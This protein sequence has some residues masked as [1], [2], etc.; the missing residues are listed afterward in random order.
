[1]LSALLVAT[2]AR[3]D[4]PRFVSQ[5]PHLE[6]TAR[7]AW[8]AAEVCTGWSAPAHEQVS[9]ASRYVRGGYAGGARLD[10]EGLA[11]VILWSDM[12]ERALVHE[13][14]HAWARSGP[15]TLTEGRA[16]LLADCMAE[17]VPGLAP[18]DP[19]PGRDLQLMPDLR[20]WDSGEEGPVTDLVALRSD[21]YLASA[22]FVR[23]LGSV[24]PP[25]ALWPRAGRLDW[26]D[27]ED[28][29]VEAG[30]R[31]QIVLSV[32][33]S[34]VARQ[35]E[36]LSD[37]DRDGQPWLAEVL[38][39]THPERWDSDG[40]GWWD[41]AAPRVAAVPLPL[42]GTRICSG[43]AGGVEPGRA[44]VLARGDLRGAGASVALYAGDRP[45]FGDPLSGIAVPPEAPLL[46]ALEGRI[47]A[48]TGG[49]WALTGGQ[50][51]VLDWNCRSTPRYTIWVEDPL[52]ALQLDRFD[53]E[54]SEQLDRAR[55]VLGGPAPR[56]LVLVLGASDAAITED[57]V[58]VSTGW[59][60]WARQTG[61]VDALAGVAVAL[62]RVWR[63]DP[64]ERRWDTAEALLRE[65][66]D[67]A[68]DL[69][70]VAVDLGLVGQRRAAV[71]RCREGWS[72]LLAGRCDEGVRLGP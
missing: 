39:G 6:Q 41:G 5:D 19:D 36:A 50:G 15:P 23:L 35:R 58:R 61:R 69:T 48:V 1:M 17:A 3:A 33:E 22:R 37:R 24:L 47:D 54:I 52:A 31:G 21:A 40:D 72:G 30:P 56:R 57:E 16:D 60:D 18:L 68:P 46:L 65:L 55:V 10:A 7:R 51:L 25:R 11:Q 9:I 27:V 14:A 49:M 20:H 28:M 44:L 2:L 43:L 59:L 32:I 71:E 64:T 26:P 38:G 70:F 63:A 34:G 66:V 53:Q 8:E 67:D 62:H 29:L 45:L 12:P 4:A 42:D 13:V